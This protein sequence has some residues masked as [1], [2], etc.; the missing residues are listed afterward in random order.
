ME[1][2]RLAGL[3]GLTV[4]KVS[5]ARTFGRQAYLYTLWKTDPARAIREGIV[6]Q[7]A[8]AG[9]SRHHPFL[10]GKA[11]AV[12]LDA[13]SATP[14]TKDSPKQHRLGEIAIS[15]G[16]TWGGSWVNHPDYVHFE[17]PGFDVWYHYERL[18][19]LVDLHMMSFL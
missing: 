13:D 1:L 7:P 15:L 9:V 5:G 3:E 2:A 8:P 11:A 6:S 17:L 18:M 10:H 16:L 14:G 19:K 4:V 12:D